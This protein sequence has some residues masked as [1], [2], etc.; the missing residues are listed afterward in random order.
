MKQPPVPLLVEGRRADG[1]APDQMRDVRISVGVISN[2]D[3]SA[4]VSYGNTTAVAAVYGPREMHPRHLSLPDKAV[5]R[6]RY[7]MAPFSTKD[8]RKNPAPSRREIEISKVLR[9]ALEPA[10]FLEQFPRS[11]ID[12]FVEI[13]QADGSTRVAS[14]TAA[15]LALADA[16]VPMRDLVIGVSVGLVD[17]VVVLDLNGLEDNYGEGDMPVGYMPNLGRITLLQLDGAWSRDKFAEA[18]KLAVKGAEYVY[19]K[20][21][22]ALKAKYFEIAEEVAK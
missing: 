3:G 7:H 18:I 21:R 20:A 1:R 12:V 16:G 15:S 9:E 19:G 5:M 6:V 13:V 2:A 4:M 14:L 11:R 10:I 8:E 22:E 17:G